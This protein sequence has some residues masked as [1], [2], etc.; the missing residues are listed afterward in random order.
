[1]KYLHITYYRFLKKHLENH[2]ISDFNISIIFYFY[3]MFVTGVLKKSSPDKIIC[4]DI[5]AHMI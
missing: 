5:K 2:T 4:T 1:M 3:H